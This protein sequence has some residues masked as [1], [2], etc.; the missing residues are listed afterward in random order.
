[1]LPLLHDILHRQEGTYRDSAERMRRVADCWSRSTLIS[2]CLRVI[3]SV[4][5]Y[6]PFVTDS[7]LQEYYLFAL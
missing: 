4:M 6:L 1:M 2:G 7:F 3:A 5:G